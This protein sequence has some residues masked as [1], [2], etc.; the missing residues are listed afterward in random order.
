MSEADKHG[1]GKTDPA[2][3]EKEGS[4]RYGEDVDREGGPYK[5]KKRPYKVKNVNSATRNQ[6][7]EVRVNL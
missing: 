5:V 2:C 4:G 3:S 6:K 7:T 1:N